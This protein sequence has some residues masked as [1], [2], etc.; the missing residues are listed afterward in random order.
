MNF[1]GKERGLV[2]RERKVKNDMRDV[3]YGRLE[4]MA[5]SKELNIKR[6]LLEK[7]YTQADIKE[8]NT[9]IEQALASD[10]N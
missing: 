9:K 7:A 1:E 5:A 6:S 8:L 4:N 10:E 2:L 3:K